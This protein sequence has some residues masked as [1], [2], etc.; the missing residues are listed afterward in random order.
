MTLFCF[1]FFFS[2]I[3]LVHPDSEMGTA[4]SQRRHQFLSRPRGIGGGFQVGGS[5]HSS[6]AAVKCSESKTHMCCKLERHFC[7]NIH[8]NFPLTLQTEALIKQKMQIKMRWKHTVISSQ[9]FMDKQAVHPIST[10]FCLKNKKPITQLSP[11][12]S[13]SS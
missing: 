1:G 13:R 5:F 6:E 4:R 2:A 12:H 7:S 9:I 11:F 10:N 3:I 8:P